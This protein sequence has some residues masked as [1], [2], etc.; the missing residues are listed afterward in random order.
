MISGNQIN[1]LENIKK[2][3]FVDFFFFFFFSFC[4]AAS[5]SQKRCKMLM[6]NI[7]LL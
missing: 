6:R 2:H 1:V 7:W 5:Q 4:F 3:V